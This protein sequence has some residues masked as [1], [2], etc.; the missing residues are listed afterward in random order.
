MSWHIKQDN[1]KQGKL[2]YLTCPLVSETKTPPQWVL[3]S[4]EIERKRFFLNKHSNHK[5]QVKSKLQYCV[6][7][8]LVDKPFNSADYY[9]LWFNSQDDSSYVSKQQCCSNPPRLQNTMLYAVRPSPQTHMQESDFLLWL[10]WLRS[11]LQLLV[12]RGIA[13]DRCNKSIFSACAWVTSVLL[14]CMISGLAFPW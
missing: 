11:H 3:I 7:H 9:H 13:E 10:L 12:N 4:S 14:V 5:L 2:S 6:I 1:S 8:C